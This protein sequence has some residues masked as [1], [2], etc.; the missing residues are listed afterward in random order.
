MERQF[1][2]VEALSRRVSALERANRQLTRLA[3][4]AIVAVASFALLAVTPRARAVVEATEFRLVDQSGDLLAIFGQVPPADEPTPGLF[5]FAPNSS[6]PAW[7]KQPLTILTGGYLTLSDGNG[8]IRV[9]L[10]MGQE[11]EVQ[12]YDE[13]GNVTWTTS[14]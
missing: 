13:A 12:V 1:S 10:G 6:D 9:A 11:P 4:V 14:R 2:D 7:E 5:L 3:A 8:R